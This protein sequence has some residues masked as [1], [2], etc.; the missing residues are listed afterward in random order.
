MDVK[1]RFAPSP[2]GLLHF[3]SART[4]LFNWLFAKNNNGKFVLR[5]E[6]TDKERSEKKFE[7]DIL[8]NL[9][10]LGLNWNDEII[11]QSKRLDI[12]EH[13]LNKLL[14]EKKA[15]YCFC[16]PEQLEF[17]RQNQLSQGLAPKYSGRCRILNEKEALKR[18]KSEPAVIRLKMPETKESFNDLIRGKIEFNTELIGD[19]VIAK[20]L[21]E[22]LYNFAAAVDDY[23]MEITHV[24]RG[25]D[26]ISNT[27]KQLIIQKALGL[28]HPLY[29]HL[30]LILGPNHKKLSKRFLDKSIKD[31]KNNGYLPEATLNFLALLGWHPKKDR[32][33]LTVEEMIN[34]FS[35]DRIQKGGAIFNEEKLNWLNGC[36]IKTIPTN[37][38]FDYLENFI[39]KQWLAQKETVLKIIEIEK[40]R[41]KKLSDFQNLTKFFF[42]LEDY[43]SMLLIW[44]TAPPKEILNNLNLILEI[45]KKTPESKFNKE[46]LEKVINALTEEKSIGEIFWPLRAAL[47]GREASPGPLEILDVLGKKETIK[48][49]QKAIDKIKGLCD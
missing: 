12:Y 46:N 1:V 2:T 40:E 16:T 48:R 33:V 11:Y 13:Y 9:R 25:E 47:S 44:K 17:E 30:P 34:E 26:H 28:N 42:E 8:E 23:E 21:K 18:L 32:E 10:W 24:I 37:K 35:L 3:G 31:Y 14:A 39:P 7:N 36:Y 49:I 45:F 22:P 41:I 43:S 15:Y 29:A 19:I 5:I 6:D 27:P 38:L 4:A 20:N